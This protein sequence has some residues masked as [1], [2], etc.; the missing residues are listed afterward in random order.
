MFQEY[1]R[2]YPPPSQAQAFN[3]VEQMAD[4]LDVYLNHYPAGHV[5]CMPTDSEPLLVML[6]I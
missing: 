2:A 1:L 5:N 3:Y 4:R 6:L